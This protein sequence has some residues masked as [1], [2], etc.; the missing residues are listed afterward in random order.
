MA[1]LIFCGAGL[2]KVEDS[3][4]CNCLQREKKDILQVIS[5]GRKSGAW[6]FSHPVDT[7]RGVIDSCMMCDKILVSVDDFYI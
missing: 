1:G 3:I 4:P 7:F 5:P 6:E 2:G